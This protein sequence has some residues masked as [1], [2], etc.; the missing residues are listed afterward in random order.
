MPRAELTIPGDSAVVTAGGAGIG[1]SIVAHLVRAGVDVVVNDI[2][3]DALAALEADLRTVPG[4]VVTVCGDAGDP[5]D[6]EAVIDKAVTS[7][8][9][10]DILVNNVGVPGPT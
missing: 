10:L 4:N 3:P 6:V 1:R 2:D 9:G 7:H 8:D 5:T